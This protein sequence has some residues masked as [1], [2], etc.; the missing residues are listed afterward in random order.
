[1]AKKNSSGITPQEVASQFHWDIGKLTDF[2]SEVLEDA[3]DHNISLA[4]SAVNRDNYDLAC[5]FIQ[6]AKDQ[7]KAGELTPEL[8]DRQHKLLDRLSE[9]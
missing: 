8:R 3:N 9:S 7:A 2:C 6:L 4:L 1:M 5:E